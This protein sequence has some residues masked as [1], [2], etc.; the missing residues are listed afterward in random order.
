[1]GIRELEI[2]G[3][4]TR[5]LTDNDK[6]GLKLLIEKEQA[7]AGENLEVLLYMQEKGVKLEQEA[8]RICS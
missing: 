7:G 1:M 3:A 6:K 2:Y 4:S 8:V 5:K